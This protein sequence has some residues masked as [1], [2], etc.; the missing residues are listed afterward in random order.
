MA[1]VIDN[2]AF[3]RIPRPSIAH[4]IEKINEIV[5]YINDVNPLIH[6]QQVRTISGNNSANGTDALA[7]VA[8]KDFKIIGKT[9]VWNQ[10]VNL[11]VQSS[12]YNGITYTVNASNGT[13]T[14]NGTADD[15]SYKNADVTRT[16][17]LG[18]KV[19]LHGCPNGGSSSAFYLRDGY[20]EAFD[21]GTGIIYTKTNDNFAPQIRIANGTSVSNIVFK[22]MLFDLTRMFG[23]GN[24]PS[25]IEEFEAL[26]PDDYYPYNAGSLISVD[27]DGIEIDGVTQEIPTATY[28]LNGMRS[29]GSVYDELTSEKAVTRIGSVDLGTLNWSYNNGIFTA[30]YVG[31]KRMETS[32]VANNVLCVDYQSVS[33]I[34]NAPDKSIAA[35]VAVHGINII[36]IKDSSYTDAATF[37]SAMNGVMLYYELA[38]STETSIDPPI[39][40][41]EIPDSEFTV[42]IEKDSIMYVPFELTYYLIASDMLSSIIARIEA[43]E[44]AAG[45]TSG[46]ALQPIAKPDIV[47]ESEIVDTEITENDNTDI[48]ENDESEDK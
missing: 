2:L 35:N 15:L 25:T 14:A 18:H 31:I 10:F 40:L 12:T 22:P 33:D 30:T 4:N 21:Y 46:N 26:F 43:L 34:R 38:T 5:D 44:Q 6:N 16:G 23:A 13:I 32:N 42:T 45:R 28:F 41:P 39:D 3:G 27:L 11:E 20:Q 7:N 24:E 36:I 37:K 1:Q 17:F 48:T 47:K 9:V 19:L 8:A 29:A